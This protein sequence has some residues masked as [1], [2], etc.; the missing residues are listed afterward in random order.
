MNVEHWPSRLVQA[1]GAQPWLIESVRAGQLI[2]FLEQ[3]AKGATPKHEADSAPEIAARVGSNVVRSKGSPDGA[4]GVAV[5]RLHGTV[6]PRLSGVDA[7][8]GSFIGLEDFQRSFSAVADRSDVRAI[9]LDIDSPGG[10]VDLVQETAATI[11]AARREGRPI[12]ASANTMAASAAYWLAAAAD[13][14]TVTPSGQVGSIG[15]L[16]VH[17][18][19]S[20]RARAEGVKMT[21]IRSAPR[22]AENHPFAPLSDEARAHLQDHVGQVYAAFVRDV[23]AWRG[24]DANVVR[25]DP[26]ADAKHFGGG[27]T[28]LAEEAVRLGMADRVETIDQTIARA[29]STNRQTSAAARRRALALA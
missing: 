11:R 2:A 22:K 27:R 1:F 5:M 16:T 26:E 4:P 14:I 29:L 23:A 24:V 8:S 21:V 10:Q 3:R 25:A 9:V 6:A 13:E 28:A 7:M 18:D 19:V 17:Q 12:I 20:E 15:V